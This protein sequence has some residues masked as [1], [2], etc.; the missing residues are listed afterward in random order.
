MDQRFIHLPQSAAEKKKTTVPSHTQLPLLSGISGV[1]LFR[2]ACDTTK[3][4]E[5]LASH[6]QKKK[7][8]SFMGI[9]ELAIVPALEVQTGS[10]NFS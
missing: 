9:E 3:Q 10:D 8:W 5:S 4:R 1:F 6:K 2:V 7:S